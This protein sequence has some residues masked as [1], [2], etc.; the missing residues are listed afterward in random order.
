MAGRQNDLFAKPNKWQSEKFPEY[1]VNNLVL[2]HIS[3]TNFSKWLNTQLGIVKLFIVLEIKLANIFQLL[4]HQG[5]AAF[6]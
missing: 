4:I 1:Y 6:H 5:V 3:H 2:F